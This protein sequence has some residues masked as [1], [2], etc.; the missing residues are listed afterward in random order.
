M[1]TAWLSSYQLL[2]A[3]LQLPLYS[4][5]HLTPGIAFP[6]GIMCSAHMLTLSP[7]A[8]H[9]TYV[10]LYHQGGPCQTS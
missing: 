10:H 4:L 8:L 3:Q 2:A 9:V 7:A 1:H 6:V 5:P